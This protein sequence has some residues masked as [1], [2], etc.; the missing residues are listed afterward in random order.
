MKEKGMWV[1][2][3]GPMFFFPWNRAYIS[4]LKKRITCLLKHVYSFALSA[5]EN[6]K[7]VNM[8]MKLIHL[9]EPV[10]KQI[11]LVM[12]CGFTWVMSF[13]LFNEKDILILH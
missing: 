7:W 3:I 8:L 4:N 10:C 12:S 13:D 2:N 6:V 9:V 11:T 5:Q 1:W